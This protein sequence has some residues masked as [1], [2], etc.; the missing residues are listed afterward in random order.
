MRRRLSYIL[1]VIMTALFGRVRAQLT[2]V[3]AETA[4]HAVRV[5]RYTIAM[6]D[7]AA[8]DA[9]AYVPLA[10]GTFVSADDGVVDGPPTP[11][12]A[13]AAFGGA[14]FAH[15]GCFAEGDCRGHATMSR[16]LAARGLVVVDTSFRMGAEKPHPGA[17]HDLADVAAA[18]RGL[19]DGDKPFGVAGSSSGGYFA[20]ALAADPERWGFEGAF[21]FAL[22][23]CPVFN[24]YV[25]AQYLR[26]C[27][28]GDTDWPARHD[29]ERAAA[30]LRSQ[31]SYFPGGDDEMI[32]AAALVAAPGKHPTKIFV[33]L[34]GEDKNVPPWVTAPLLAFADKTLVVGRR[35]HEL[36]MALDADDLG[37]VFAWLRALAA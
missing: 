10:Q 17:L 16:S 6:R 32:E 8:I 24:P 19:V 12:D 5:F 33:V 14:V 36:Q 28:R 23:L 9:R 21:D 7:G 35:G 4:Y 13:R 20:L 26:A 3:C 31:L 18:T 29:E 2:E 1:A 37:T 25:R 30:M 11:E 15:G 22:A 34:G 27:V